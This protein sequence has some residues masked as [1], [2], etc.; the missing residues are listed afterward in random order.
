MFNRL[1]LPPWF[2]WIK[3]TLQPPFNIIK[4][5]IGLSKFN[6]PVILEGLGT[7]FLCP[8]PPPPQP[9][10]PI[11]YTVPGY[12]TDKRY[13]KIRTVMIF[14][15]VCCCLQS[16]PTVSMPTPVQ[17]AQPVPILRES[18]HVHV[19]QDMTAN[20]AKIVSRR[21]FLLGWVIGHS[22]VW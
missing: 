4:V 10:F 1:I 16:H 5:A 15:F 14:L 6:S 17:R 13:S 22:P 21:H 8:S 19:H 9:S 3:K 12:E 2:K 11:V 20:S 7:C 18:T